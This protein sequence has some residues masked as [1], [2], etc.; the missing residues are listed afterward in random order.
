[1]LEDEGDLSTKPKG[2]ALEL[3]DLSFDS[4]PVWPSSILLGFSTDLYFAPLSDAPEKP[5]ISLDGTALDLCSVIESLYFESSGFRC[6][7]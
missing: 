6:L 4:S 3:E 2:E 1:M 7:K 5:D